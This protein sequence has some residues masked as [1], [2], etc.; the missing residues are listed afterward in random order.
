MCPRMKHRR[1]VAG[2]SVLSEALP[3]EDVERMY[4]ELVHSQLRE[5]DE[6]MERHEQERLNFQRRYLCRKD[7]S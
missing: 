5:V 1:S 3:P 4:L 6:L 7:P 2:K